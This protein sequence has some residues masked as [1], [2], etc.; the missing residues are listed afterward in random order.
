MKKCPFLMVAYWLDS[1]CVMPTKT[2]ME[3][4]GEDCMMYSRTG[5]EMGVCRLTAPR[6][7]ET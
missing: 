1:D 3:C 6:K 2:G 4:V 7:E 5:K